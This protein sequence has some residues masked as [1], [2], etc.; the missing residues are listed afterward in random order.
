[1]RIPK[2]RGFKSVK[3]VV[4]EVYTSQLDAL[5]AVNIDTAVLFENG[6]ISNPHVFVKLLKKGELKSK[7]VVILPAASKQAIADL[8]AVGGTYKQ[9]QRIA[10]QKTLK[11][12]K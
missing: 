8:E 5:K 3:P 4:E 6:L 1:M 9:V 2:L 10:R 12:E 11:A 7:K